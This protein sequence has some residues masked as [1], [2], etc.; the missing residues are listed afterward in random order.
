MARN[1]SPSLAGVGG[2]AAQLALLEQVGGVVQRRDVA[3]VDAGDGERAAAVERAQ[4]DRD[5]LADRG[6]ED[7]GVERLGRG[8]GGVAGRAGA[9]LEG[10]PA[11]LGRSGQHVHRRPLVQRD[12]GGEVGRGAEPVDAEPAARRQRRPAQGAEADDAGAQQRRRLARRRTT[13]GSA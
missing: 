2:D 4:G 12:L 5:E 1:S 8:V 9:E 13:S 11:G 7:G 3:E 6:E 10:E